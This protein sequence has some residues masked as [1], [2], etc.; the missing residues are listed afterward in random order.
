M[1]KTI[2][3]LLDVYE[4]EINLLM[5]TMALL[6]IIRS[7]G[8][9]LNNYAETTFLKRYGVEYLPVVNMLNAGATFLVT[10]IITICLSKLT[11]A[12][13]LFHIFIFSGVSIT[14]IRLLIPL[15][16][17]ILYPIL[18]M[19]KSQ[20]ELLQAMLFWNI[21]NDL[22]N[23]RQS[24]R[25]F[26]LLTAGGVV[27]LI[28]GS[29]GTPWFAGLFDLDNLLF[30]YLGFC[31]TG[32]VLIR[33]MGR[34]Y[35]GLVHSQKSGR[36]ETKNRPA[37]LDQ[38]KNMLPLIKDSLLLKLVLVLT[39][40]PNVLI[41]IMNYQFNYVVNDQ[42][43][44]ESA[45]LQFFGWFR[46]AQYT[47]SLFILLFVGKIYG[48]WGMPV[49]LMFHP[50]NYMLAFFAFLFRFDLFSALYA[51]ISTTIIRTTI[52]MPAQSILIGLFPESYRNLIRPILRGT[53]V[54]MALF[55]GSGLILLSVPLFHPRY[56]SLVA[57]PFAL[58]WLAAPFMLKARYSDILMDLISKNLL[59][60]KSFDQKHLA[61]VFS[62]EKPLETLVQAFLASRG[63]DAL[64][65]ASLLKNI[66]SDK[67][68]RLIPKNLAYQDPST[69]AALIDMLSSGLNADEEKG[70][71]VFLNPQHDDVTIAILK[72]FC[73]Q[74]H[75][76]I[77]SIDFDAYMNHPKPEIRGLAAA[78]LYA[79]APEMHQ[80]LIDDWLAQDDLAL[81]RAG[82]ISAGLSRNQ[83]QNRRC[84]RTLLELVPQ[85]HAQP[86][87]PDIIAALARLQARELNSVVS[88]LMTSATEDVRLAALNALTINDA[89][90]LQKAILRLGDSSPVVAAAA[91][92]KIKLASYQNNQLLIASLAIP[93]RRVREAVFEL[94][95]TLD[96]REFDV[97]LF[98]NEKLNS[99]YAWLAMA[100]TLEHLTPANMPALA[101]DH[102]RA[103]KEKM[104]E[105]IIRVLAIH[106]QS[107]RMRSAWRGLFS[108]DTRQRANAIELLN[109]ILG[110]K[111]FRIL[112]PLLESPTPAA[113]LA[114]GRRV[115]RIPEY[116]PDGK[117]AVST[118]L[119]SEDWVDVIAGLKLVRH[120][121]TL[122]E[123]RALLTALQQSSNPHILKEA[124][125]IQDQIDAPSELFLR[126]KANELTLADKILHLKKIEIFA[127]LSPAEL[128]AIA[129][130]SQER[131]YPQEQTIFS[132]NDFG[133]TVF[134]ILEGKVAVTDEQESGREKILGYGE[135]GDTFGE[136]AI[137]DKAPRSATIRTE[138]PCRFLTLCK[139]EFEETI[140]EYPEIALQICRVYSH[141]IR[142]LQALV[143]EKDACLI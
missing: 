136:M 47:I 121:A 25:L 97:M 33:A 53:V 122:L 71:T 46:G 58:V 84:I 94:L 9:I 22:F 118:L 141:R 106:D 86:L 108:M 35:A 24:K 110:R 139:K 131:T 102:L 69:R 98:A 120:D 74:G 14:I 103:K 1:G 51:R 61:A 37:L 105:N 17:D 143:R 43:A 20:Y 82:V 80:R 137:I 93:S 114:A 57:L 134:M 34:N 8:V 41:P 10:G 125:M 66:S 19:L 140:R 89:A 87:L 2:V 45:L 130:V 124:Q 133:E 50:F 95:E 132:K 129:A 5:W 81:Q 79:D 138:T 63:A 67:L 32:A 38:I 101:T 76:A 16:L 27:G 96:I 65:Y 7:S 23:T 15:G 109:G 142:H 107:G 78:C 92:T 52:N 113:A 55:T 72:R 30:L 31:L 112:R 54:R 26:P 28:L 18:F 128:A 88:E 12:A 123:D 39:F 60:L 115:T 104:L 126:S 56:L 117:G 68:D 42:F 13:L 29:F 6:F 127:G 116:T 100:E 21:C 36:S 62:A 4:E 119:T 3:N 49:A 73:L 48:R 40:M 99:C 83:S 44:T 75:G 111:I 59:A 11:G 77:Q 64:W 90:S 135:I 85:H 91:G 70:L